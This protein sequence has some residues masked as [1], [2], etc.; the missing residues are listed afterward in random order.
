MECSICL[1]DLEGGG[2]KVK[3]DCEHIFH[4]ECIINLKCSINL[5]CVI[6]LK[7]Y[8]CPLCRR[9]ITKENELCANNHASTFFYSPN[10][11]KNGKCRICKKYS[12]KYYLLNKIMD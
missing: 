10:F 7:C 4:Y 6:N 2:K 1:E 9:K 12:L 5:K 8:N 3:L 11:K